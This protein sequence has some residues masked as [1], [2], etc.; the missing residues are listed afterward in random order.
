MSETEKAGVL[1]RSVREPIEH[2]E[3]FDNPGVDRVVMTAY[4]FTSLCPITGQPDFG[5]V[6]IEYSPD[7]KCIESKSL[8]LYLWG[9]RERGVF[10][11][12]LA[13][14]ILKEVKRAVD[15]LSARV[16]VEQDPRG[17]IGIRAVAE[18]GI[19]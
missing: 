13:R 7:K 12:A 3:T 2:V 11:E 18:L 19:V 15:P 9:F 6:T 1:G 10:S 16:I 5:T 14:E 4:E 17:G 8:K